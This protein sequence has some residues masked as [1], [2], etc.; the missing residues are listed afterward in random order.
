MCVWA[1]VPHQIK[2][3]M[4]LCVVMWHSVVSCTSY[5]YFF[6]QYID[7][8]NKSRVNQPLKI[9]V[10]SADKNFGKACQFLFSYS[11][12]VKLFQLLSP[13]S[14]EESACLF[15][16]P[17]EN[18][19]RWCLTIQEDSELNAYVFQKISVFQMKWKL[20]RVLVLCVFY[21]S[22]A[23]I[24]INI[25]TRM[26]L[27][28]YIHIHTLLAGER[29]LFF[30][31]W[32]LTCSSLSCTLCSISSSDEAKQKDIVHHSILVYV[33]KSFSSK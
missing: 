13:S 2:N 33:A 6:F 14:Q 32:R 31:I 18:H 27:C 8:R 17:K 11:N 20:N 22:Y 4:E 23:Y 9:K 16:F 25:Y 30:P 24:Y 7:T 19:V 10:K 5:L 12:T 3:F 28:V 21:L 26:S 15:F 1:C 29:N